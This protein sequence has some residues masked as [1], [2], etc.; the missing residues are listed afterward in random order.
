MIFSGSR[1]TSA[2]I[3]RNLHTRANRARC[4]SSEL[5]ERATG[6]L[7]G[8]AKPHDTDGHNSRRSHARQ[9]AISDQTCRGRQEHPFWVGLGPMHVATCSLG[10]LCISSKCEPWRTSPWPRCSVSRRPTTSDS[11]KTDLQN[12]ASG[13]DD[14]IPPIGTARGRDQRD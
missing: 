3:F 2:S 9:H 8:S 1:S 11:R 10:F 5:W 12:H 6:Q 14:H 13:R 7:I 4:Q